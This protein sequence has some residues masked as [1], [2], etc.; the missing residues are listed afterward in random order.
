MLFTWKEIVGQ[1]DLKK[2]ITKANYYRDK[3]IEFFQYEGEGRNR[4]YT[5]SAIEILQTIAEGYQQAKTYEKIVEELES[6]FGVDIVPI[7]NNK[8]KIQQL[9]FM[10]CMRE[11]FREELRVRDEAILR[12][13]NK[14]D[15]ILSDNKTHDEKLTELIRLKQQEK[16]KENKGFFKSFFNKNK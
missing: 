16:Q 10:E 6:K 3:Y 4:K 13:E 12:L 1:T 8:T 2:E 11:I 7:E 9:E 14:L 5:E 15:D